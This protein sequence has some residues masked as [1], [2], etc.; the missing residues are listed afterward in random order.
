MSEINQYQTP[1][2]Q[3]EQQGAEEFSQPR[4]FSVSGRIGRMRFLAYAMGAYL[5]ISIFVAVLSPIIGLGGS[6][7]ST[8]GMALIFITTIVQLVF[9]FMFAIQRA[10]DM[11]SSGWLSLILLIPLIGFLVF[12]F[13]PGT[14]GPNRFGAPAPA[15]GIGVILLA[16]IM[17]ITGIIGIIAA[18]AIPAYHGYIERSQQDQPQ[19]Q[20]QK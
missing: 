12:M 17:P 7:G 19:Y 10:H 14:Q 6:I 9:Y 15:N 18:I 20:Q 11:N 3:V 2:S 5:V 4:I 13:V 16:L 8:A 1:R